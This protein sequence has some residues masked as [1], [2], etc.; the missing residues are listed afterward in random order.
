MIALLAKLRIE[1]RSVQVV[2]VQKEKLRPE[3]VTRFDALVHRWRS[4]ATTKTMVA[5][6]EKLATAAPSAD[7]QGRITDAELF[8]HRKRTHRHLVVRQLL[9]AHSADAALVVVTMP[10]PSESVSS[11]LWFCWIEML[12]DGL[13]PTLLIRGNHSSV[14]TYHS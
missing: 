14:L 2:N 11:C 4:S 9:L 8:V 10:L 1:V 13:P 6:D 7:D 3:I 12:T 5:G